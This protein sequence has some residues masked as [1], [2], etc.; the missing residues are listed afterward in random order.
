MSGAD[1]RGSEAGSKCSCGADILVTSTL[2][3]RSRSAPFASRMKLSTATDVF[4]IDSIQTTP[5]IVVK[6]DEHHP[7]HDS[8][9]GA[10]NSSPALALTCRLSVRVFRVD[11]D[12]RSRNGS[13]GSIMRLGGLGA[14]DGAVGGTCSALFRRQQA[15]DRLASNLPPFASPRPT[16]TACC[17]PADLE[18]P[19]SFLLLSPI[20][21]PPVANMH[22]F[23]LPRWC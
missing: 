20:C 4:V 9:T 17:A 8:T 23:E 19:L 16:P 7:P 3:A 15:P 5:N 2:P 12:Q 10:C 13:N 21:I 11:L 6:H 18:Q 1:G 22:A 14:V